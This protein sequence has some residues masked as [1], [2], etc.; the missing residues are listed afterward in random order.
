M[1]AAGVPLARLSV[2]GTQM[3]GREERICPPGTDRT[4]CHA[5]LAGGWGQTLATRKQRPGARRAIP[6]VSRCRAAPAR[7]RP[8]LLAGGAWTGTLSPGF[9]NGS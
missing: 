2:P 1:V 4:V 8:P 9:G 7:G 6:P 3:G 5:G